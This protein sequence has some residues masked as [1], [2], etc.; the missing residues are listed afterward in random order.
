MREEHQKSYAKSVAE[1]YL[2]MRNQFVPSLGERTIEMAEFKV[3]TLDPAYNRL[4]TEAKSRKVV[5][6]HL[7][8]KTMKR[9][10]NVPAK[11][12]SDYVPCNVGEQLYHRSRINKEKMSRLARKEIKQKERDDPLNNSFKPEINDFEHKFLKR[13]YKVPIA[14]CLKDI[15]SK[16]QEEIKRKKEE[17]DKKKEEDYTFKPKLNSLSLEITSKLIKR[18]AT[19]VEK[20]SFQT[21]DRC[22]RFNIRMKKEQKEKEEMEKSKKLKK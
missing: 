22:E 17:L 5:L 21:P 4:H 6:E 7:K 2:R 1:E 20:I 15:H 3:G 19:E 9:K 18:D 12:K 13:S 16:V 14:D 10:S 8:R 11:M